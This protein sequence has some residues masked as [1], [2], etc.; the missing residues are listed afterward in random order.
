MTAYITSIGTF[1]PGQPVDNESMEEYIGKIGGKA[2]RARARILKQNGIQTRYYAIDRNQNTLY[3]NAEMA[4]RAVEA[5]LDRAKIDMQAVDFL[6]A[7]T[8]QG[9]F[10]LPGFASMVHGELRL[11]SCEIAT[12]HGVCASGVMALKSA[13]LQVLSGGKRHAVACSSEFASRLFKS[14]RFEAQL[15]VQ[16]DGLP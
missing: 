4:A 5:A 8:S 6:A 7:A 12:L 15:K 2:S 1:F 3:S 14:S 11:P 13:M 10:P 16:E 9:D